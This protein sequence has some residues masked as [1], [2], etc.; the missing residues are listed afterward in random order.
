M[1]RRWLTSGGKKV[2]STSETGKKSEFSRKKMS[3]KV[4]AGHKCALLKTLDCLSSC[5]VFLPKS[6]NFLSPYRRKMTNF[7]FQ[8]AP[9]NILRKKKTFRSVSEN[10]KSFVRL[11]ISQ[12]LPPD[13]MEA[14]LTTLR[15]FSVSRP[16][17]FRSVSEKEDEIFFSENCFLLFL[18]IVPIDTKNAIF[19]YLPKTMWQEAKTN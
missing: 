11:K 3:S 19:T 15:R 18:K 6:R 4:F 16:E 9:E 10:G 2:C 5:C 12:Y 1:Q 17:T 7:S 8:K 14:V 13:T